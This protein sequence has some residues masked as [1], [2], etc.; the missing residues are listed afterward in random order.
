MK[1]IN[2]VPLFFLILFFACTEEEPIV[3]AETTEVAT[4]PIESTDAAEGTSDYIFD[5]SKLHTFELN[6]APDLLAKI[7]A[8]PSAEEYVEG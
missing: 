7:D 1:N 8:D 6:L 4:S 2:Y 3:P 5:Q